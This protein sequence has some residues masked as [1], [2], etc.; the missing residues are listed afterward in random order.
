MERAAESF[1]SRHRM[2]HFHNWAQPK[3]TK[4]DLDTLGPVDKFFKKL[5]LKLNYTYINLELSFF[6]DTPGFTIIFN[7][8][9]AI[10]RAEILIY[11]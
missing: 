5:L 2:A 6:G 4:Y 11:L 8:K 1:L 10:S 7:S 3:A 9:I